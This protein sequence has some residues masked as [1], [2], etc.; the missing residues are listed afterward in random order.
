MKIKQRHEAKAIDETPMCPQERLLVRSNTTGSSFALKRIGL[1][2][3][4]ITALVYLPLLCLS[5]IS[6]T[7][8]V[9]SAM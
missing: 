6:K 9:Y 8:K 4:I 7:T 2:A 3:A 1:L 5:A